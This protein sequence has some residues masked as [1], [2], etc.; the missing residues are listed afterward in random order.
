MVLL[1]SRVTGPC[2]REEEEEDP[3]KWAAQAA[4]MSSIN[5]DQQYISIAECVFKA[6]FQ[7]PE[8]TG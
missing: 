4:Y 8:N 5:A 6:L 1:R 3:K 2:S 7:V